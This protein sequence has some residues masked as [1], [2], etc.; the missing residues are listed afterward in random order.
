VK[1]VPLL[2]LLS[3]GCASPPQRAA[4]PA[5]A[6]VPY[7]GGGATPHAIE[8]RVDSRAAREVLAA[9]A[10]PQ[11][12]AADGSALRALPAVR[13]AIQDSGRPPDVFDRDL[14]AAFDEESR[15]AVFDFR[16]IRAER[17][18]WDALLAT[19][20]AGESELQGKAA[21]S[22]ATLLPDDRPIALQLQVL[23]S[24]GLAGLADHLLLPAP[25][26]RTV[27]VVDLARAL[28]ESTSEPAENQRTRLARLIAGGAYRQAWTSYRNA[29]PAWQRRDSDLGQLEP[30][31][32]SVAEAG[33]VALFS[34]DENFFPLSV[35]LKEP[36]KRNI[37]DLNR[38]AEILAAP[39]TDLDKRMEM[40]AEVRRPEFA[41]RLAGPA[42]A[43]LSDAIV[44]AEGL[45]AFRR[46]LAGGPR[47]FFQAY[48]RIAQ[49]GGR[50]AIPLAKVIQDRIGVP[51]AP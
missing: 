28:G 22:V 47:A 49:A 15:P 1:R 24:F 3:V 33:P 11:F 25:E 40:T 17:E 2:L 7:A 23:L 46:A 50:D 16:S 13:L 8:I 38:M 37:G 20:S 44:Q 19:V 14:A 45:P 36:M 26:G 35:W 12:E 9:M 31:L 29:S 32:R 34:V 42:G 18:R 27:M 21:A 39:D 43:F 4:A 6:R 30:L 51:P 48:D 5:Q 41:R 10:R